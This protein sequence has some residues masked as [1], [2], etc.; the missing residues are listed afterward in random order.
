MRKTTHRWGLIVAL[1][2]QMMRTLNLPRY[3]A[4]RWLN[5][6]DLPFYFVDGK[7]CASL[8]ELQNSLEQ[9]SDQTFAFHLEREP[10]DIAKWV[11][12]IIGDYTI[13]SILA[14]AVNR[15]QMITFISDHLVMLHEALTCD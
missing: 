5:K 10:N 7:S 12:D 2:R 13:A 3:V 14:E 11:D 6:A 15:Q 9:I 1:E 8:E 4:Q